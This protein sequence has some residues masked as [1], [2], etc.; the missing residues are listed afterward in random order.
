MT[1]G[2]RIATDTLGRIWARQD[3]DRLKAL[4]TKM[5]GRPF[6]GPE[7]KDFEQGFIEGFSKKM[8]QEGRDPLGLGVVME[9]LWQLQ[10]A[11]HNQFLRDTLAPEREGL[12][13]E[14]ML[15]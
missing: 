7:E 8:A 10:V 12:L 2:G 4:A 9:Y 11:E 14:V 13:Q 15:N 1:V 3:L 5:I 6:R